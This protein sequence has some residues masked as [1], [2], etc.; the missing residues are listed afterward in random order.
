MGN[1]VK[2]GNNPLE[3]AKGAWQQFEQYASEVKTETKRV[4]WPSMQEVYGTTV[5]VVLTT[6]LFGIYFYLCDL[7]FGR[8]VRSLLNHFLHRG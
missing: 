4:T 6:F 7:A 1:E 3:H 2:Q 8:A 5:M